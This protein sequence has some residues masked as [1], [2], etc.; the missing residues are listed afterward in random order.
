MVTQ[1]S[2]DLSDR[3][4]WNKEN[5]LLAGRELIKQQHMTT[6]T[7]HMYITKYNNCTHV[8]NKHSCTLQ[9]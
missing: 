8:H 6:L 3:H 9:I 2:T 7:V 5:A 1:I 4:I